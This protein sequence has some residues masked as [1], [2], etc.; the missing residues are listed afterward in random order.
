MRVV[1][2]ADLSDEGDAARHWCTANL[3]AGDEVIVVTGIHPIGDLVLGVPPFDV[4][5]TSEDLLDTVEREH[6]APLR[7]AG[8]RPRSLLV[9]TRQSAAVVEV[10]LDQR[11][12]LVVVGKHPHGWIADA[13]LGEVANQVV[14]HPPCPVV[15]VPTRVG[16][17]AGKPA[18][19][20]VR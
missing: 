4:L 1:M 3:H 9:H 5:A 12:D 6:C 20:L 8:L 17:P 7:A 10:A 13:V 19:A 2:S 15:V 11:A 16:E 18:L 14:H